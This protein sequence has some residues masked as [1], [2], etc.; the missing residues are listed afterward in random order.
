M[1]LDFDVIMT[2]YFQGMQVESKSQ[3]KSNVFCI[4]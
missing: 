4:F 3:I 1:R 2:S